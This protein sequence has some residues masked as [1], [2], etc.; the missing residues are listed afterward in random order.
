MAEENDTGP[1]I[2]KKYLRDMCKKEKLYL[3]PEL[4]DKLYLHHKGF[5]RIENLEEYSGLKSLWLSSNCIKKIENLDNQKELKCL[6]V[7]FHSFSD[8]TLYRYLQ[9][10]MIEIIENLDNLIELDTLNISENMINKIENLKNLPKLRS[11][12]VNNNHLSD[13]T[14]LEHLAE[15][16]NLSYS[17]PIIFTNFSLVS[18]IYLIIR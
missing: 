16:P 13:Y 5:P 12:Q 7:Y 3:T 18:W 15:C 14:D 1:R 6:Y 2:T 11:L 4:N 9:Q 8:N 10:N 17:Y